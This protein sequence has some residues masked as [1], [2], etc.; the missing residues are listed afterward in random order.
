MPHISE[1]TVGLV[2]MGRNVELEKSEKASVGTE[3]INFL[4]NYLPCEVGIAHNDVAFHGQH[5]TI[6]PFTPTSP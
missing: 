2:K 4:E 5:L 6:G 3:R 1:R